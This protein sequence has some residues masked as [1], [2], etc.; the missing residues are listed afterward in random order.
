M[1]MRFTVIGPDTTVSFLGPGY[2]LKML[3]AV[4]S[5]G[6]SSV[7]RV[8]VELEQFD[9]A[10][11]A[12]VRRDLAIFDEHCLA[13]RPENVA[14]W[15]GQDG[16]RSGSAFRV[17]EQTTRRASTQAGRLGLVIFNLAE[18]RIV[19][20]QN[21]YGALL[22][23]DRGRVRRDGKPLSR[24]YRYELPDEWSIVP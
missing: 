17:L 1:D 10:T 19:Q 9:N 5:G 7:E 12:A 3:T 20:I 8:L 15:F 23:Q 2:V 18:R 11:A 4:V 21:S 16:E 13:E 22:R 6:S 24:F 14:E